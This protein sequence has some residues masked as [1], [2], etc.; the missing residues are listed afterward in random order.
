[1]RGSVALLGPNLGLDGDDLSASPSD[2]FTAVWGRGGSPRNPLNIS[3]CRT[4]AD[5]DALE[6]DLKFLPLLGI[7]PQFHGLLARSVVTV[8]TTLSWLFVK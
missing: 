4:T 3:L 7:E 6:A 2:L 5:V 1:M 8:Q